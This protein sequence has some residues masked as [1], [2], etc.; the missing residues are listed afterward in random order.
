MSIECKVGVFVILAI[1]ILSMFV[2][3][4]GGDSL[5]KRDF[6]QLKVVF[7]FVNGISVAA[8]VH[9]AGVRVGEVTD[10]IIFFN[11]EAKRT[12]VRLVLQVKKHVRV[13][14]DSVAYINTLGILGEKY[15]EIVPGADQ[16]NSLGNGGVITGNNPVQLEK[17]TESLVD[18]VGDQTV[19]ESLRQSFSN[20]RNAS[21]ELHR[22]TAMLEEM[23]SH[24]KSGQGTIGRFV[25]DEAVYIETQKMITDLNANLNKTVIDLNVEL[26]GLIQD[27]KSHPWKLLQK[28]PRTTSSDDESESKSR[29]KK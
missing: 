28:P 10:V 29:R 24:V 19:R 12:Q 2:F 11:A 23:V 7:D 13:P 8:P 6:Y 17:L 14:L 22:T 4:I 26:T 15:V 3:Q 16:E 25:Y 27:L 9:V 5:F 18:I 20:V 1:A 21:D